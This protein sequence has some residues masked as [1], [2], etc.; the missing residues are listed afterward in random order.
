VA[1]SRKIS[2]R[3]SA[4]SRMKSAFLFVFVFIVAPKPPVK[5]GGVNALSARSVSGSIRLSH[6]HA[7]LTGT[8]GYTLQLRTKGSIDD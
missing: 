6:V 1:S 2:R 5:A 7:G 4:I 8:C 3:Y